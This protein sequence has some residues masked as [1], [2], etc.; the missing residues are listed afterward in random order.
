MIDKL[1]WVHLENYQILVARSRNKD[2]YYI[3]GGKREAGETDAEALIREIQEE[4]S[5]QLQSETITWIGAFEA[6]AHGQAEGVQVR[7]SCYTAAYQGTLHPDSEI[8]EMVYL[9]YADRAKVS[10][11]AQLLFDA[12]FESGLLR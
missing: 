5:V 1:A 11:A 8:E 9:S 4:L 2:L 7:L 12:L 10:V 6:Q 3:P